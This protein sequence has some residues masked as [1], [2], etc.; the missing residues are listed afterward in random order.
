MSLTAREANGTRPEMVRLVRDHQDAVYT[1]CFRVL[2]HPQDA[3]DAAQEVLL[4]VIRQ[5]HTLEDPGR[6]R[7][8]LTRVA[9][10]TALDIRRKRKVRRNREAQAPAASGEP[11][12]DETTLAVHQGIARLPDDDRWV[13]VEHFFNR[14]TLREL[15][16]SS[17]CSEVAVWKRIE[18]AKERLRGAL[19]LAGGAVA[20]SV[21][22]G[23]RAAAPLKA[24]PTLAAGV[25][26]GAAGSLGVAAG[27]GGISIAWFA[28][29]VVLA[30]LVGGGTLLFRPAGAI[31]S[32]SSQ[33]GRVASESGVA[34]SKRSTG[35]EPPAGAVPPA[36]P[37]PAAPPAAGPRPYPYL[38]P[39]E[40][41]TA[42]MEATRNT[43]QE[44]LLTLDF[45]D[46]TIMEILDGISRR[47]GIRFVS[48]D[49]LWQDGATSTVTFKVS[50]LPAESALRLLLGSREMG[51]EI[52]PDGS[53]RV[54]TLDQLAEEAPEARNLQRTRDELKRV[55]VKLERGWDGLDAGEPGEKAFRSKKAV[56]IQGETTPLEVLNSLRESTGIHLIV[57]TALTAEERAPLERSRI[58]IVEEKTVEEHLTAL[59]EEAG[60][61]F[62]IYGHNVQ[63]TTRQKAGERRRTKA[64]H[65]QA[66]ERAL[67]GLDGSVPEQ[68]PSTV[69]EMV[70]FLKRAAGV[71][72]IPSRGVWEGTLS[73][74]PVAGETW[75]RALDRLAGAGVRWAIHEGKL[76]LVD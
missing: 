70:D 43:L 53:I 11:D 74:V 18:R 45:Q 26:E 19:S 7:P 41:G 34:P 66:R 17:C 4:E 73:T 67:A 25:L 32:P 16:T 63:V 75:R 76:Y 14:K 10:H 13:L 31:E 44:A 62:V 3:E 59:C 57:D 49:E 36:V 42:A 46:S 48:A 33:P 56:M 69:P 12:R 28:V 8:W 27:T 47:T 35:T 51:Y 15:A 5:I 52:R 24:P 60:L 39:S 55:R 71:P 54:A 40:T 6:M 65:R 68:V 29:P 72:V 58:R 22:E 61:D 37:A 20:V 9:F 50:R 38:L 23:A 64:D 21:L 1:V 2:G 30:G